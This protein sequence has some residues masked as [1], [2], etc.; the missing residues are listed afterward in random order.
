MLDEHGQQDKERGVS[1]TGR[2]SAARLGTRRLTSSHSP[3]STSLLASVPSGSF[4][5]P[6]ACGATRPSLRSSSSRLL[7]T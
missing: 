4:G 7:S 6:W 1:G 3:C 2:F 5:A